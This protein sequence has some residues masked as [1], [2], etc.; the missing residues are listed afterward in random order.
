MVQDFVHPQHAYRRL[1]DFFVRVEATL[2]WM[3]LHH[4]VAPPRTESD[5]MISSN[6]LFHHG[7][8]E[9]FSTFPSE[10]HSR[11]TLLLDLLVSLRALREPG[12]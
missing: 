12:P 4:I 3:C 11:L 6:M 7:F 1:W 10:T 8:K 5:L 9:V 2:L